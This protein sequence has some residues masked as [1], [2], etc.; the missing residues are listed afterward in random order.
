MRK[1]TFVAVLL[2]ISLLGW[3]GC[4]KQG[5]DEPTGTVRG[6]VVFDDGPPQEGTVVMFLHEAR[7][8]AAS[9]PTDFEGNYSLRSPIGG[10]ELPVGKYVVSVAAPYERVTPESIM[11][12]FQN[13]SRNKAASSEVQDRKEPTPQKRPQRPPVPRRYRNAETSGI[14]YDV[15]EGENEFE[16]KLELPKAPKR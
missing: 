3:C 14:T 7:G 15:K 1:S 8:I 12:A 16:I 2:G 13:G 11:A 9:S 6:R 5:F 10:D 4:A